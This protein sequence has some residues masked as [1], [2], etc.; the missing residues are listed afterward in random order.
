MRSFVDA[1]EK[2]ASAIGYLNARADRIDA[3]VA[4]GDLANDGGEEQYVLLRDLLEPL[5]IPIYLVPGNH[6]EVD[7][8]RAAFSDQPWL[9]AGGP[10]DYVIDDHEVRLI[11]ID[12]TEGGRHDGVFSTTQAEWLDGV[13]AQQPDVPTMLFCHHPPFLTRLWLFDAIRLSGSELLRAVVERHGQV[14]HI[15]S[16]HVHRPVST[17]WGTTTLTTS[18]STT[19]QS[20]CDLDPDEGAGIVDETPML[21]LHLFTG[22]SFITHS[23]PFEP[24]TNTLEIGKLVSDWDAARDRIVAGPPFP[25]G[26]GGMF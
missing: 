20:R 8:F 1:N 14:R 10:I 23:T 13:L 22:E 4:T 25:K 7:A 26:P 11:G 19:H 17:S 12:T 2:L 6:D 18:P 15:V 9:P 3:V 21:Q 16:G 24:A 5:Q